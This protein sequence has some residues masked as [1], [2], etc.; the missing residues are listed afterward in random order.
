M[1]KFMFAA[2]VAIA[3]LCSVAPSAEARF[4]VRVTDNTGV[5]HT[6]I[7]SFPAPGTPAGADTLDSSGTQGLINASFSF[8]GATVLVTIGQ[9][10]P[11]TG[12]GTTS[13]IDIG[14]NGTFNAGAGGGTY[15]VDVTDT[16]FNAPSNPV[17]GGILTTNVGGLT[18][19]MAQGYVSN[20]NTEFAG[21]LAALPQPGFQVP[22]LNGPPTWSTGV[23]SLGGSSSRAVGPIVGPYSMGIR[24]VFGGTSGTFSIDNNV[25]FTNPA[26]SGLV[27][28]LAGMP[29]L[30]LRAWVR[31]RRATA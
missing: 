27:L 30:G 21:M 28:A 19:S 10:K 14:I 29:V 1:R 17:G 24:T 15:T 5:V 2:A 4:I 26:P 12:S 13:L 20:S 31:R 16:D 7:D 8:A 9:S 18:G 25:T 11:I 6:A 22:P 23:A 3:A